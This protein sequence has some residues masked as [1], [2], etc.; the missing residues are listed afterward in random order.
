MVFVLGMSIAAFA[1][2]GDEEACVGLVDGD[3][4]VR[5]DGDAGVCQPD[6]SDASILVCDDDGASG[7]DSGSGSGCDSGSGAPV[8]WLAMAL[9]AFGAR[10]ARI[11]RSSACT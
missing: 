11:S 9:L 5:A 8:G 6:E 1:K 3:A 2:D 7:S 10:A 4:C